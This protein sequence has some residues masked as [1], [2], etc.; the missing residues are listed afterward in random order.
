MSLRPKASSEAPNMRAT[1]GFLKFV[2][3]TNTRLPTTFTLDARLEM[4]VVTPDSGIA[5]KT[6]TIAPTSSESDFSKLVETWR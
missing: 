5:E 1:P 3:I 6:P 4:M 2:S